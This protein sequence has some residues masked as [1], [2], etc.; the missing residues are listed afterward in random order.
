MEINKNENCEA[1]I[2]FFMGK[3]GMGK[4]Y[5]F[6]RMLELGKIDTHYGGEMGD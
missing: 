1:R 4:S 5:C 6:E 3:S 2:A